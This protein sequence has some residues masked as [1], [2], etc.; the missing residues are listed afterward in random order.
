MKGK[1]RKQHLKKNGEAGERSRTCLADG[2]GKA[3][4]K[5]LR[6]GPDL[7][8]SPR[9]H[10]HRRRRRIQPPSFHHHSDPRFRLHF[11]NRR[12]IYL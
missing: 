1:E 7:P 9:L 4:G 12:R 6:G 10:H 8:L 2:S 11:A 5:K 3:T